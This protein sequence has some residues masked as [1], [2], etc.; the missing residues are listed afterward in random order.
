MSTSLAT[1]YLD[2][3]GEIRRFIGRRV[4]C[5]DTAHDL[6]HEAFVRLLAL[7]GGATL[8]NARAYLFRVARNLTIDH[9]RAGAPLA[10]K[11]V[12][13]DECADLPCPGPQ[14]ERYAIARQQLR[15]LQQAVENLPPRCREVFIRH[16][17]DGLP[18]KA[19]AAEYGVTLNAIEK[20]LVRALVQLRLCLP[21]D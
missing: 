10:G 3:I 15:R 17:F 11:L 9:F 5:R 20:L 7:D 8:G 2:H 16:K 12:D 14:P 4:A 18:Q 19:L 1:L 21:W 13:L 6:A